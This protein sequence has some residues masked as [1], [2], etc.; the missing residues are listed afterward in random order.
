METVLLGSLGYLGNKINSQKDVKCKP[1]QKRK[2]PK[3]TRQK[4]ASYNISDNI[5][6]ATRQQAKKLKECGFA[7]QF[8]TIML[9]N[10]D[11]PVGVNESNIVNVNGANSYD[12]SLQRDIDLKNGYSEFGRTQMHYDVVPQIEMMTSNMSKHSS[13]RDMTRQDKDYSQQLALHTG[14]DPYYMSKDTH[15]PTQ[16][17]EPMADLTY[18]NGAPVMTDILKERYVPSYKNNNGDLPFE[19]KVKVQPGLFGEEQNGRNE[20]YR[21]LPKDTNDLRSKTNQKI[22]YKA[23]KIEAV[24]KGQYRPAPLNLTKYKLPTHRE[25]EMDDYLPNA[26][27]A[28]KKKQTGE[29]QSINTNRSTSMN[30]LGHAHDST[31]GNKKYGK[32]TESGKVTFANDAISRSVSNVT[33]NPVLQNKKSFRNV[34]NERDSTNHNIPGVAYNNT[35]GSYAIDPTNIPLTTLRQLMIEGDNNIGVTQN[36]NSNAYIFSKDCVI[37]ETHRS[38]TSH[39]TKEGMM[40]PIVKEGPAFDSEDRARQTI[41]QTTSHKSVTGSI[42]PIQ[43]ES[44]Y[45]NEN[46]SARKTIKETTEHMA[47]VGTVNPERGEGHYF[48]DNDTA[49]Q[50]IRQTTSNMTV[51]GAINPDHKEG[52]Y[53]NENDIAK[54]TIKETTIYNNSEGF[55]NPEHKEGHYFNDND[56]AKETIRQTTGTLNMESIVQPTDRAPVYINYKDVPDINIRNTTSHVEYISNTGR[57][58]G[59]NQYMYNIKEK[60][61]PTIRNTTG[62]SEYVSNTNRSQGNNQYMYNN[63]EKAR[64]TIRNTTGLSEYVSNANRSQGNVV[65]DKDN[66]A[67]PTIRQTTSIVQQD[68]NVSRTTQGNVVLGKDH[69]AKPTIRQTTSVAQQD[70]NVSR[71]T[72]GNVVIGKHDKAKPTIKQ[73]TLHSTQ[74]GRVGRTNGGETY[75]RDKEDEARE[76]VKQTTLH[77]TQEGRLGRTNGGETYTRD[78][79]DEAKQTIRQTTLHS[80]QGGRLGKTTGGDSY[81]RDEKDEAKQ[82]IKQ[83]TLHSTQAGRIGKQ[84]GGIQ[85]SKDINDTARVT[86]RQTTLLQNHTGPLKGD[87]EKIRSQEAEQNMSIDERREI[88]TYNRPAGPK[89]DR[90]G[91]II[92]KTGIKFKEE[93]FIKRTNFGFDKSNCNLGQLNKTFTRN[94]QMLNTPNY[95]INDD[96]VNTLQTNPLVNNIMHQKNTGNP[97]DN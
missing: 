66:I 58:N 41:R 90:A 11:G 54:H 32:T 4:I 63:N 91:P 71:T 24:Q 9:D 75:T 39:N 31:K 1:S 49:R 27:V 62:L 42:N 20:V 30:V 81:V 15:D 48:N 22:S 72:Q 47:V 13:R 6:K 17:F 25:R 87:V 67:K 83:T 14:D 8:D 37:P 56:M 23:D 3:P 45:Y 94:K 73:S 28:S 96:F 43:R 86:I 34:E 52:H 78:E 64:P 97:Y 89:S 84:E 40:N 68:N 79:K 33:T 29:F 74:G 76:T 57:T 85:Y 82:T 12:T 53:Y 10:T 50:T 35:E 61:K 77:S 80:T 65:M 55:V 26:G 69:I 88:L 70:N 59:N 5:T 36:R 92:N 46:D 95:R 2:N 18:V 16:L 93:N 44:H 19:N 51:T 38:V 60:A 21:V 7:S